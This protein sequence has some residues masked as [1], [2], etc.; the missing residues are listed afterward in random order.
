MAKTN[1]GP[2]YKDYPDYR[3]EMMPVQKSVRVEALGKVIVQTD[4]ALEVNETRHQPVIYFPR[5][6]VRFD[7]LQEN[8][9]TTYCPFKGEARYWN[10]RIGSEHIG[11]AVW[12]YDAPYDEVSELAGYVAFYGDRVDAVIMGD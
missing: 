1:P 5:R 12:G 10:I 8:N 11:S 4:G 3:V 7:F 9:L 6:D 2:G